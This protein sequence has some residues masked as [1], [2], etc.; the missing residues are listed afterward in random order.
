MTTGVLIAHPDDEAWAFTSIL[1]EAAL[2][3]VV[4][5]M[6]TTRGE[7]G[8]DFSGRR[9]RGSDLGAVRELELRRSLD[10][11][12][13]AERW[14]LTFADILDASG[15]Q[16]QEALNEKVL[17]WASTH[18]LTKLF[19]WGLAGG[20]GHVDHVACFR[21]ACA[22]VA[23]TNS[24]LWGAVL[25]KEPAERLYEFLRARVRIPILSDDFKEQLTLERVDRELHV[26]SS[27]KL[28]A[29]RCHETQVGNRPAE[30]FVRREL[31]EPLLKRETFMRVEP[32]HRK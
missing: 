3:G 1:R 16:H 7:A 18:R 5:V 8:A 20:Y 29:L 28:D 32:E 2:H 22:T 11:I 27:L 13:G 17:L 12:C 10:V 9:L 30:D 31:T 26:D 21:A 6:C 24:T 14:S 25:E 19:T 23:K 4:Q 15:S